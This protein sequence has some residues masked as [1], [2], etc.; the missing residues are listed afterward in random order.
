MLLTKIFLVGALSCNQTIY[1]QLYEA[2]VKEALESKQELSYVMKRRN[3]T[4]ELLRALCNGQKSSYEE[5][6]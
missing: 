4:I 2:I 3:N 1:D 6:K 5:E